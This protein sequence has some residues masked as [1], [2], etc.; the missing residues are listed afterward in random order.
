VDGVKD[1]FLDSMGRRHIVRNTGSSPKLRRIVER[2][3]FKR[4]TSAHESVKNLLP[5]YLPNAEDLNKEVAGETRREHLRD[6]EHIRRQRRLQHDRHVRGIEELDGVRSPLTT[7]LV[8][9]D[10]DLDAESLE[11]DDD[12]KNNDSREQAHN[13]GSLSLQKA[14]RSARPLSCHVNRRWNSAMMAPSN[15]DPRPMLTVVGEKAFQTMDSQMLVAM[16]KLMPD[17]RP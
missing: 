8:A 6:D 7:E 12:G 16:N 14:S 9:L 4:K 5:T 17:P 3:K 15:S 13:V 2:L 10:G 11:V 1:G